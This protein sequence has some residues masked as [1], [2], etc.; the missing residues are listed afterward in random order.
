MAKGDKGDGGNEQG[1]GNDKGTSRA[2][3]ATRKLTVK[4]SGQK[5]RSI[6]GRK[7]KKTDSTEKNR[8]SGV[9]DSHAPEEGQDDDDA[10]T[11]TANDQ[12][13]AP[14]ADSSHEDQG[15]VLFF[16]QP[17]PS[18]FVDEDGN[19]LTHYARNKIRTAKYTPLSFIPKNL[20]F[21]FHNVANIFFLFLV[22]LVVSCILCYPHLVY[23]TAKANASSLSS[24][25]SLEA[26]TL[27]SML[28]R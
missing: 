15:R 25:P 11:A 19:P 20:W 4:S 26:L 1:K 9:S 22:I 10:A 23:G 27:A 24:S 7:H 8:Q 17:L 13:N 18:E 21:Q 12:T 6:L 16:N 5:R 3:W 2:R 14:T 28:C